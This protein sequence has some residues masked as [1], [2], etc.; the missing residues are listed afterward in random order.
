MTTYSA[1]LQTGYFQ[2]FFLMI[3]SLYILEMI[4]AKASTP[5]TFP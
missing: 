2:F 3:Y 5:V 1:Y 4:A